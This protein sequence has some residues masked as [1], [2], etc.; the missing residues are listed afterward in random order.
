MSQNSGSKNVFFHFTRR[1]E[2][3]KKMN[4]QEH[5]SRRRAREAREVMEKEIRDVHG[6][7]MVVDY[8]LHV[9]S[10]QAGPVLHHYILV[11]A[12]GPST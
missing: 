7:S 10:S 6:L 3:I 8:I 9:S 2:R 12:T 5:T 1:K 4:S 11:L